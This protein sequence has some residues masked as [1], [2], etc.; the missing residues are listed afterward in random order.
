MLRFDGKVALITGAGRGLGRADAL[1]LACQRKR[2]VT[3]R[4]WP[5]DVKLH[6]VARHTY[7]SSTI[8]GLPTAPVHAVHLPVGAVVPSAQRQVRRDLPPRRCGEQD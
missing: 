3:C 5:S 4:W 2:F 7:R 1:L 8:V 6:D